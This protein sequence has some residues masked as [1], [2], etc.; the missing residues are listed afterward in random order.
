MIFK[1]YNCDFGIK[2]N[3]VSYDFDHVDGLTIEDPEMTK[4]V[5]GANAANK[6]GLVYTEGSKDPKR[7]TVTLVGISAA[8]HS[9][10]LGIY[11]SKERC[12]F[13]CIDRQDGSSK[14]GKDAILSQKPM[15][16][17][18]DQS[19]ESMNVSLLFETF[20]LEESH[21]S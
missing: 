10:L 4:L 8:M 14:I 11:N 13:Y 15:Q 16:L 3:G 5:R 6:V 9:L 2:Y 20:N 18:V 21:K 1:M 19:P 17:T 7:L 12:E